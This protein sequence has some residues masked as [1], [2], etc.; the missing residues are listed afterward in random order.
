MPKP[1]RS[2]GRQVLAGLVTFD[3][4]GAV[5]PLAER[6][7]AAVGAEWSRARSRA[8]HAAERESG[9]TREELQ[10]RIASNPRLVPLLVRLMHTAGMNGQDEML[11]L[12]GGAFGRAVQAPDSAD[13]MELL[14]IAL[15]ELREPHMR[16]LR[17]ASQ[18]SPPRVEGG[19][20]QATM[21]IVA[22]LAEATGL[23]EALTSLCASGLVNAGLLLREISYG[24]GFRVSEVGETV[25]E[26]LL[27]RGQDDRPS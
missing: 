15:S 27:A 16:V 7:L 9:M 26:M 21:W 20:E 23:S 14:L 12:L 4:H 1:E 17:A 13:D 3:L 22:S 19:E 24:E 5:Q 8:L 18:P 11:D 25:I 2:V 10:E 6:L